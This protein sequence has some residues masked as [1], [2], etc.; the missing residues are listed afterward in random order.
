MIAMYSNYIWKLLPVRTASFIIFT[1]PFR[2]F[3][4][5]LSLFLK[6]CFKLFTHFKIELFDFCFVFVEVW[7]CCGWG[8]VMVVMLGERFSHS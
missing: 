1:S 3:I 6:N 8:M 4:S 2:V 5:H 7:F